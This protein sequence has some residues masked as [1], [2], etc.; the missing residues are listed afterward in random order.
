MARNR[1]EERTETLSFFKVGEVYQDFA[2][3]ARNEN[4]K[5]H[6]IKLARGDEKSFFFVGNEAGL[7]SEVQ[8]AL[9]RLVND[10]WTVSGELEVSFDGRSEPGVDPYVYQEPLLLE[11]GKGL[12]PLADPQHG[13]QLM[14]E[15]EQARDLIARQMGFVLPSVKVC[16]NLH[17]DPQSYALRVRGN[18]VTTGELFLDRYFAVASLEVLSGLEG[19]V[20]Q[21]PVHRM[22]AKW[23]ETTHR[24]KAESLGCLVLGPLAVLMSHLKQHLLIA[25]PELLGLQETFSLISRLKTSHPIVVEDFLGNRGHLRNVRKV[26]RRLLAERVPIR[27][28]VTILETCGDHLDLLSHDELVSRHCRLQLAREICSFYLNQ[29]GILRG[30]LLGAECQKRLVEEANSASGVSIETLDRL[31]HGLKKTWDTHGNPSVL[32][33]EPEHRSLVRNLLCNYFPDLG[34]LAVTEIAPHYK[35]EICGTVEPLIVQPHSDLV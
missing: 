25:C 3:W 32:F 28:L 21:D 22:P 31:T 8:Q 15:L 2:P 9:M 14:I 23:I 13:D 17:G 16:D 35:L 30:L 34:V 1:P 10:G 7:R 27:D 6:Y 20:T 29:E 12:L 18:V 19:W 26:L 33:T 4:G 11:L 24:E 5:H